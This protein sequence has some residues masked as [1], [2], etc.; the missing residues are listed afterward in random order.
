[1]ALPVGPSRSQNKGQTNN[2]KII[3]LTSDFGVQSQGVG[4]ME[5]VIYPICPDAKVVHL[6]HGIPDFN[7][8]VGART[9]ETVQFMPVGYHVCVVDP[10]VGTN[11]RAIIIQTMRGD[12]LIGPD[13]GVLLPIAKIL[14]IKKVVEITNEKFM[15]KPVSPLFHG[16]HIFAPVAAHLAAGIN[17]PEFGKEI[18]PDHLTKVPYDEAIVTGNKVKATII[19]I[20]KYGSLHLNLTHKEFD[21]LVLVHNQKVTLNLKSKKITLP[22]VNTFGDVLE[23]KEVLLKDDYGRIEVAINCGN[24]AKKYK[25]KVGDKITLV[26]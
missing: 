15:L 23:G 9:M 10:G 7:L 22:F 20:N 2:M 8:L 5:A 25:L 6:M 19:H 12:Y 17:I 13:N 26:K 3:T 18:N 21:T 14:G 1:M 16:R 24:F 11:R 4:N